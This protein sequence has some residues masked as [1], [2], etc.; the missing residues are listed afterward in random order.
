MNVHHV[1]GPQYKYQVLLWPA[2]HLANFRHSRALG[3]RCCQC[4]KHATTYGARPRS[5]HPQSTSSPRPLH[6]RCHS[7]Y[8]PSTSTASPRARRRLRPQSTPLSSTASSTPPIVRFTD[9]PDHALR[10]TPSF[11]SPQ[12][13]HEELVNFCRILSSSTK[14]ELLGYSSS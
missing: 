9:A 13:I 8:S 6:P 2:P 3:L 10:S 7:I 1:T 12:V 4:S 11:P 14:I 5:L